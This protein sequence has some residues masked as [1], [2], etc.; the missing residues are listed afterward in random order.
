[1]NSAARRGS[2]RRT[3]HIRR[4]CAPRATAGAG[5]AC[6]ARPDPRWPSVQKRQAL[7]PGRG[8]VGQRE[9]VQE[10]AFQTATTVGDQVAFEK[11]WLDVVPFGKRTYRDLLLE[12]A[13]RLRGREP[14]RVAEG[15][16]QT[17]RR[18]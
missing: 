1:M 17:I 3:A 2:A 4:P 9:G 11:A 10:C 13:P 7:R 16:K 8:D 15:P 6:G 18:G 14:M 5:V 12:Q